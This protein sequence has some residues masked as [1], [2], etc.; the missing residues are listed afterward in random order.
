MLRGV[1]VSNNNRIIKFVSI[2]LQ[3]RITLIC[4]TA[5]SLLFNSNYRPTD[6]FA[7]DEIVIILSK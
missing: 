4:S 6:A 3:C 5:S 7:L 2:Y 1:T